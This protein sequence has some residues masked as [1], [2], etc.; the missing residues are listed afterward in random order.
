MLN[1]CPPM[2]PL[3]PASRATMAALLPELR[4]T[5]AAFRSL[6][7]RLHISPVDLMF[8]WELLNPRADLTP[9]E[10]WVAFY[11]RLAR[12][13]LPSVEGGLKGTAKLQSVRPRAH[14]KYAALRPDAPASERASV[15]AQAVQEH[16][17]GMGLVAAAPT[18]GA[19]GTVPGAIFGLGEVLGASDR[20][21]VEALMVA[22]LM[23]VVAFEGGPVSGAQ[24]GCAGEIGVAAAMA[25][26]AC[27]WLLGGSWHA[28][29]IAA[30]EVMKPMVGMECS[31]AFG[32]V[33]DPCISRN[34][35]GASEAVKQAR[36]AIAVAAAGEENVYRTD[37]VFERV[38]KV[39]R[40]LPACARETE[41]GHW[42]ESLMRGACRTCNCP[43]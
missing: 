4:P 16:N 29:D 38:F 6:G 30:A 33:E 42:A 17:A 11:T 34:G 23:G 24:S 10:I 8:G 28:M 35:T 13:M 40:G 7:E 31:P 3:S 12:V 32:L 22:G 9:R 26:A 19:S 14:L 15:F 21:L 1:S 43:L 37:D 41:S 18:G 27:V 25:A 39:G 20:Q 5:W 36:E 2:P